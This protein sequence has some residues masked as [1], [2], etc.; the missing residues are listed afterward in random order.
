LTYTDPGLTPGTTYTYQVKAIDGAG[1]VS[2]AAAVS[3]ATVAPQVSSI[4]AAVSIGA[5]PSCTATITATVAVT[6]GPVTVELQVVINGATST[7]SVSFSGTGPASQVLTVGTGSGTQDGTVQISSTSPNPVTS[8]KTWTAPDACRPGFTVSSPTAQTD[9]CDPPTISGSVLV[10]TRNNAGSEQYTV[11]MV[12]DGTTVADTTITLAPNS[13]HPISLTGPGT[14]PNGTYAVF[15][16]VTP[17]DGPSAT[18]STVNA[19]VA[20]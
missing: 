2:P 9:S 16:R 1:N 5:V 15:Y 14:Y 19:E 10:T 6:T 17:Q 7:K 8:T 20:C 13:F 4:N 12:I 11:Q 3:A 18:S